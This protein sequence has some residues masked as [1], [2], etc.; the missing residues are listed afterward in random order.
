MFLLSSIVIQ[1]Y[2]DTYFFSS[3]IP[4]IF[5]WGIKGVYQAG[6]SLVLTKKFQIVRLKVTF[7]GEVETAVRLGVKSWF[8]DVGLSTSDS[9]LGL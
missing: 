4:L 7:L 8:A 3:F 2:R 5:L 6:T 9:I 1:G